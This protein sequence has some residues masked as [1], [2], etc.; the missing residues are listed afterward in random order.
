MRR[1]LSKVA[2]QNAPESV[3]SGA[4][5]ENGSLV[6]QRHFSRCLECIGYHS[7]IV[8]PCRR[9]HRIADLHLVYTFRKV[10]G[11]AVNQLTVNI[12]NK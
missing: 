2:V 10:L 1:D 11:R 12:V 6:Q 3:D 4:L 7:I 8:Y 5:N 9:Q